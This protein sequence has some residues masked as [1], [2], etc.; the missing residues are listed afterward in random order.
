VT[1]LVDTCTLIWL[2]S[3]STRLPERVR[4]RL[5]QGVVKISEIS[6][7]EIVIKEAKLGSFGL[8]FDAVI[9]KAGIDKAAFPVGAHRA[10]AALP[11]HHKDPFDRMLIAHALCESLTLVTCDID[12]RKY[13]VPTFW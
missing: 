4:S 13:D 9:A 8:D 5:T 10:F 2:G 3:G 11:D 7:I 6:R 1:L 12:I